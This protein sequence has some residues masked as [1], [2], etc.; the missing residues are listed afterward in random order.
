MES[1]SKLA[2]IGGNQTPTFTEA[3]ARCTGNRHVAFGGF[4][5]NT[6]LHDLPQV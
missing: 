5:T 3:L 2:A 4:K 1:N 6:S